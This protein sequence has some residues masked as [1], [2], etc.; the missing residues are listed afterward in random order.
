MRHKE[1]NNKKT[2]KMKADITQIS[3]VYIHCYLHSLL[4]EVS[5]ES[6]FF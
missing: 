6:V 5:Q 3:G 4:D 2:K 1:T